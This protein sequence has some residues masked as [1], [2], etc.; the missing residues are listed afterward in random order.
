M[1]KIFYISI[2]AAFAVTSCS[3]SAE[4]KEKKES[5][6]DTS[7]KM[8]FHVDSIGEQTLNGEY[9]KKYINGIIQIKGDYRNGQRNGLWQSWYPSGTLWSETTFKAGVKE[10]TTITYYENGMVR[11]R[12]FYKNDER[13]GKW[14]IFDES[15]KFQKEIDYSKEQK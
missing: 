5:Q 2:L 13:A 15:G 1:N 8:S 12:G 10:G 3:P 4:E 14:K 9:V 6:N 11:Y 7:K